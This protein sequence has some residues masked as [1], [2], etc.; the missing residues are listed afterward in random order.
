MIY[1]NEDQTLVFDELFPDFNASRERLVMGLLVAKYLQMEYDPVIY[2]SLMDYYAYV[3]REFFDEE[4]GMVYNTVGKNPEFKRLYNGPWMGMFLMEM[5]KVTHDRKYLPLMVKTMMPYYERGGYNFYPNGITLYETIEVLRE[6]GMKAEE[7][8]LM[9]MFRKHCDNI[10]RNGI[11]Y[12]EHEVRYEQTIVTPA[13]NIIAQMYLIDPDESLVSACRLH[14]D[15]LERFN[16]RQPSYK[17]HE[18]SLRHWDGYWFGK[19]LMYGDTLP[20]AATVHTANGFRHYALISGD[21]SWMKRAENCARCSL[22]LFHEDGTAN[23][24]F[25]YPFSVNGVRCEYY[26]PFANEQDGELYY[27]IKYFDMWNRKDTN[28]EKEI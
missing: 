12:P 1:D 27:L 19:R 6:A 23:T 24:S 25:L 18:A 5:Y 14:V 15:V 7:E 17:L 8:Q 28:P 13:V 3:S 2:Q 9:E 22:C 10:V 20:H 26:D 21:E 4:T 16:G 11:A